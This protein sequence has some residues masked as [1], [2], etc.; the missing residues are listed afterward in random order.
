MYYTSKELDCQVNIMIKGIGCKS[1][2]NNPA[3]WCQN[4]REKYSK[5]I[6][7]ALGSGAFLKDALSNPPFG[8]G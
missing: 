4:C 2:T 1:R 5:I 3:D 6:A 8:K 7:P